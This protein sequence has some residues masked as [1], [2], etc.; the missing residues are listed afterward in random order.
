MKTSGNTVLITGGGSG[1]GLALA[2]E[3]LTRGNTVV[4]CD[5]KAQRLREAKKANPE[6]QT[7]LCDVRSPAQRK[8]LIAAVIKK[9][10]K[11]NVLV[12]N[13]AVSMWHD[14]VVP[15]KDQSVRIQQQIETNILAPIEL[16][17][18]FLPHI[19]KQDYSA[20]VY[21][22]SGQAYVP[23]SKK[24]VYAAT[25]AAIHSFSQS[26][27]YQLKDRPVLVM[28]ALPS[29][30]DTDM[31]RDLAIKKMSPEKVAGEIL[32]GLEENTQELRIGLSGLLFHLSR[33]MPRMMWKKFN[34]YAPTPKMD[35]F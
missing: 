35:K 34:D 12:N 27:R 17:R 31:I 8:R 28:E 21:I 30:V 10:S 13:A 29:W 4:V 15:E 26:I 9:F 2:K 6:L 5:H 23:L 18:L 1:I 20:L 19:L 22:T 25:K 11:L 16:T 14:F 3:F 7:I 24:A 32:A 33:L